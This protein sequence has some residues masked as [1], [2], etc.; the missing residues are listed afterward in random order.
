MRSCSS[1]SKEGALIARLPVRAS[2]EGKA[3]PS[4]ALCTSSTKV[5]TTL[6]TAGYHHTVHHQDVDVKLS[7]LR[8]G[9]QLPPWRPAWPPS[10]A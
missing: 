4:S 5:I 6:C 10:C 8:S 9:R 3:F 7:D 1:H 2:F